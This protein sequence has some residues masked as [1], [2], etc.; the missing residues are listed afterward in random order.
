M[1]FTGQSATV[2][3]SLFVSVLSVTVTDVFCEAVD[4]IL[5][6]LLSLDFI[7]DRIQCSV[8]INVL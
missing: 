3:E 8:I 6:L 1:T 7:C 5:V 2:Q 4:M